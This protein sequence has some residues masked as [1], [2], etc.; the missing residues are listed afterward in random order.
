M[1]HKRW[2]CLIAISSPPCF[3]RGRGDASRSLNNCGMTQFGLVGRKRY[4]S[5]G[6]FETL[7]TKGPHWPKGMLHERHCRNLFFT[8]FLVISVLKA[9]TN[10]WNSN[11]S[12][13]RYRFRNRAPDIACLR[14]R[15]QPSGKKLP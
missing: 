5:G 12:L 4:H 3:E 9:L 1:I 8:F 2:G 14:G 10:I 15:H 7:R 13:S 11:H 6:Q